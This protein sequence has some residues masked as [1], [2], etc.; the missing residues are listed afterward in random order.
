MCG[1]F[2]GNVG[3]KKESKGNLK[4]V[5][6]SRGALRVSHLL[7]K[8]ANIIFYRVF[9]EDCDRVIKVLEDYENDSGQKL[10]KEKTSLFFSKNTKEEV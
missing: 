6:V 10:N 7:F 3:K 4:G 1:R 8:D 9:V 2:V 5:A